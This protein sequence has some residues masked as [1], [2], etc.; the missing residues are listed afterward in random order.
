MTTDKKTLPQDQLM[1]KEAVTKLSVSLGL[2]PIL[3]WDVNKSNVTTIPTTLLDDGYVFQGIPTSA[4]WN[5]LLN[6]ITTNLSALATT[7]LLSTGDVKTSISGVAAPGWIIWVAGSIGSATSGATV[8]ANNDTQ[9]LFTLMWNAGCAVVG[10][11]GASAAAD[12]A[13]NK[14]LTLPDPSYKTIYCTGAAPVLTLIGANEIAIGINN[15][16]SHLHTI[17]DP[18]H[19]HSINDPGHRHGM[20]VDQIQSSGTD[21]N[22]ALA[23]L[24]AIGGF[25]EIASTGISINGN[26][27]GITET[28]ASGLGQPFSIVPAAVVLYFHIKL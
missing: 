20:E 17:A 11:R 25:T 16:P 24:G 10:G 27:T 4:V 19:S 18:G 8:R 23:D 13:A 9:S 7:L 28:N 1:S 12:W 21:E 26:L 5:T 14:Q 22:H 2:D 3:I 15:L 6:N